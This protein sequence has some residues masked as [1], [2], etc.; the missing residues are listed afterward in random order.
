MKNITTLV[1]IFFLVACTTLSAQNRK[2]GKVTVEELQEKQHPLDTT[3]AA[4]IL[5]NEGTVTFRY[6][7]TDGFVKITTVKTKIKIYKKEGYQ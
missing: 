6:D 7:D 4:A 1:S 5:F 3:A 2:L